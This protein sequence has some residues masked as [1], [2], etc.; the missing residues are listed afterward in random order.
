MIVYLH[1]FRSSKSS[2]KALKLK[3]YIKQQAPDISL[4]CEDL[5]ISPGE[6]I[7]RVG[8]VLSAA[9]GTPLLVGSS[10]GGYYATALAEKFDLQA[11]LI[12]PACRAADLLRPWIGPHKNLYTQEVFELTRAHIE[13][14][15]ALWIPT[16]S[17]PERFWVLLETGDETL[18]YRDALTTYRGSRITVIEGGSHSLE[19]FPAHLPEIIALAGGSAVAQPT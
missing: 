4:W 2:T 13:E 16:L 5:P 8:D 11:V 10:L 17:C 9:K 14:L 19:S 3:E 7:Q 1:G 18:D 6:A 15:E 12:N